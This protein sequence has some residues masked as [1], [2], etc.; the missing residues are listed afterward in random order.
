M[1]LIVPTNWQENLPEILPLGS[2][3]EFY[4]KANRDIIGGG[5][6]SS[7]IPDPSAGTIAGRI[8]QITG[9]RIRFNYLLNATCTVGASADK[10]YGRET[11]ELL[12]RLAGYGVSAVT[13]ASPRLL[14]FIK[15]EFPDLRVS[16]STQAGIRDRRGASA[17]EDMG[18][19]AITL[20]FVDVNRDFSELVRIRSAVAC[21]LQL[22]AN[23]DCLQGCPYFRYHA[24]ITA[25]ASEARHSGTGFFMDY[26]YLKCN[27][28]RLSDPV[29]FMRSGWIRPEDLDYY[30][31]AGINGV[32]LVS[33]TMSTESLCRVVRAYSSGSYRG[34]LLD[35]FSEPGRAG[36][37]KRLKTVISCLWPGAVNPFKL[38]SFRGIF[39]PRRMSV[40][41]TVLDGFLDYFLDADCRRRDC[42]KCGYCAAWAAKAVS[43]EP[44]YREDS[45]S[46]MGR[47]LENVNSGEVF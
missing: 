31:R 15:R 2:I 34:N 41:N 19:D 44:G 17:W 5:R 32:K 9:K 47:M 28:I 29:E 42:R 6:A 33:R 1:K 37:M 12:E 7:L 20:S 10:G 26:C 13:V 23:L 14:R 21:D 27:V 30:E 11:A 38:F 16:V 35:L 43:F 39:S 24:H 22:I 40:D 45:L 25:H 8:G 46:K 3:I 36:W 4:G 18:A